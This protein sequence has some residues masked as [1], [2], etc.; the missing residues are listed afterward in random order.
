MATRVGPD[1]DGAA[2]LPDRQ[3]RVTEMADT[4]QSFLNKPSI[5]KLTASMPKEEA[6]PPVRVEYKELLSP[7]KGSMAVLAPVSHHNVLRAK[8]V[9]DARA[10]VDSADA[11]AG[12]MLK[13]APN[14]A[15]D[16]PPSLDDKDLVAWSA[17]E[18]GVWE[19]DP[20][21]TLCVTRRGH[22]RTSVS[23][24]YMTKNKSCGAETYEEQQGTVVLE[25]G[26]FKKEIEIRIHAD[27]KWTTEGLISV[28][29]SNASQNAVM[30]ELSTATVAVLND[31]RFPGGLLDPTRRFLML[32][33]FVVHVWAQMPRDCRRGLVIR[34][35]PAVSFVI[36][37]YVMITAL[38]AIPARDSPLLLFMAVLYVVNFSVAYLF[39]SYF[40]SLKLGGRA[41]RATRRSLM[42]TLLQLTP[43]EAENFTTGKANKIMDDQVGNAI[44][45]TW[46]AVFDVWSQGLQLVAML[47]VSWYINLSNELMSEEMK[48]VLCA[49]PLA[50]IVTDTAL[51]QSSAPKQSKLTSKHMEQSDVWGNFII[52]SADLR[53]VV[54]SYRQ[55]NEVADSFESLHKTWNGMAFTAGNHLADTMWSAKAVPTLLAAALLF[56]AG[57]EAMKDNIATG[58]EFGVG[59]GAGVALS[60]ESAPPKRLNATPSNP[61]PPTDPRPP[62]FVSLLNTTNKFGSTLGAIFGCV[63]RTAQGYSSIVKIAELLNADTRR[64]ELLR[65]RVRRRAMVKAY[66]KKVRALPL[67]HI[68]I[69]DVT[70]NFGEH[71][72][73]LPP[74]SLDIQPEL[75]VAIKSEN[76][77]GKSTLLKLLARTYLPSTG[78]IQ[79]PERWRVRYVDAAPMIFDTTL[80]GN[81]RFGNQCKH[82]EAEIWAV[83]ELVGLNKELVGEGDLEV[84]SQ[85]RKLSTSDCVCIALC[86]AFLSS[87]NL[88]LIAGALDA[89][90]PVAAEKALDAVHI[91]VENRGFPCLKTEGS[92]GAGETI[93]AQHKKKNT[94][95]IGTKLEAVVAKC[96]VCVSITPFLARPG[97][98]ILA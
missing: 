70:Y 71:Y 8:V 64:K 13:R 84:G 52:S 12:A 57:R 76:S 5:Q 67:D 6:R 91:W 17:V 18:Y 43:A 42:A 36:D 65:G 93:P 87:A 15:P 22:G 47:G 1:P 34:A 7:R 10:S 77:V 62:E 40:R 86:R 89:L 55:G 56:V 53:P 19:Y 20:A 33:G 41:T 72:S 29:L 26:C 3:P 60:P 9:N 2:A 30:G 14:A 68:I 54:T 78:F 49:L 24:D 38:N 81:L 79:Y 16:P 46:S 11:F 94:A 27:T 97:D 73:A 90:G 25:P 45:T 48:L 75:V 92:A 44:A 95:V 51:L 21:V 80:M 32:K 74:V 59:V 96:D 83:C 69:H 58:G 37:Q 88:L 61:P 39:D 63:F 4:M 98:G 82:T 50:M 31:D 66:E 35:Y 28:A 85:G 23:V